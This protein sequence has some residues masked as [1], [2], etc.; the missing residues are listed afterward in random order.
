[1]EELVKILTQMSSDIDELKKWK[2]ELD[3]RVKAED[4][5]QAASQVEFEKF[6]ADNKSEEAKRAADAEALKAMM[7]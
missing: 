5:A 4:E 3:A 1:M 6:I 2:S 7:M